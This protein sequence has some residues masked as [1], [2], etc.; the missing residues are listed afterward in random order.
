M[1]DKPHFLSLPA[2]TVTREKMFVNKFEFDVRLAA[3]R[4]AMPISIAVADVD[5]HGNDVTLEDEDY[6]RKIQL[7]TVAPDA[8]TKEWTVFKTF[9]RPSIQHVERLGVPATPDTVGAGGGIVLMEIS[10]FG[11]GEVIY[12]Y[13]DAL[14]VHAFEFG[15]INLPQQAPKRGRPKTDVA[16]KASEVLRKLEVTQ[17]QDKLNIENYDHKRVAVPEDLFVTLAGPNH[18]LG[19]LGFQN[20]VNSTHQWPNLF[21]ENL[22]NTPRTQVDFLA[23]PMAVS[24]IDLAIL[25]RTKEVYFAA[26]ANALIGFTV[27]GLTTKLTGS[28][29]V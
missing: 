17:E 4:V 25:D 8:H 15:L 13:T 5:R 6:A 26:A 9:F 14:I 2:S 29:T 3:A 23:D 27:G 11:T 21:L 16:R 18:L 24:M 10:D 19:V 12:H 20:T 7:K 22:L 1:N 28:T